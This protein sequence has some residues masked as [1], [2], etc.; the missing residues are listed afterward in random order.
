MHGTGIKIIDNML[1]SFFLE[2]SE[3]FSEL[4]SNELKFR[5]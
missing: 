5:R 1:S 4:Q 2:I 3:F